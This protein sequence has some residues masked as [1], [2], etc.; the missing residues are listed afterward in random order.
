MLVFVQIWLLPDTEMRPAEPI[1]PT[2]RVPFP[3]SATETPPLALQSVEF[4]NTPHVF[5]SIV[6]FPC[7]AMALERSLFPVRGLIPNPSKQFPPIG[8]E[9]GTTAVAL[10]LFE[11]TEKLYKREKIA[12]CGRE[13]LTVTAGCPAK[14]FVGGPLAVTLA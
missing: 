4:E 11:R 12:V 13:M 3:P 9:L 14:V 8:G 6:G 1:E 2:L 5:R 7:S 10:T